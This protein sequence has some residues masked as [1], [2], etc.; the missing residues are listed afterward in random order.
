MTFDRFTDDLQINDVD[1]EYESRDCK[2][3][4]EWFAIDCHSSMDELF[5]SDDC[6]VMYSGIGI[7]TESDG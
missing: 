6:E 1:V 2:Q 7:E 3:C 5:C 4:G